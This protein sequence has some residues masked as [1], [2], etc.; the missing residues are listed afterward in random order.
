MV[1]WVGG[2]FEN[3][4]YRSESEVS[5]IDLPRFAGIQRCELLR[6]IRVDVARVGRYPSLEFCPFRPKPEYV[7]YYSGD[8]LVLIDVPIQLDVIAVP[9]TFRISL[10]AD[11]T[12]ANFDGFVSVVRYLQELLEDELR[13]VFS[14]AATSMTRSPLLSSLTIPI[15]VSFESI[16]PNPPSSKKAYSHHKG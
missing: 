4:A 10:I 2:L 1:A 6:L 13:S 7:L 5:K 11:V 16:S 9:V 12:N 15:G 14:L 8:G 3:I